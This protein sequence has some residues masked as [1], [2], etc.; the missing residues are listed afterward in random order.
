MADAKTN[1]ILTPA[2]SQIGRNR[3]EM[4]MR[5]SGWLFFYT[6]PLTLDLWEESELKNSIEVRKIQN[7]HDTLASCEANSSM[8][9]EVNPAK[10]D[11]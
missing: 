9:P 4:C 3:E 8:H 10:T 2:P 5:Q 11:H 6:L 1:L 7:S